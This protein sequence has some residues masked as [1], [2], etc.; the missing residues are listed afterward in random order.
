MEKNKKKFYQNTFLLIFFLFFISEEVTGKDFTEKTG[1]QIFL[2]NCNVCHKDGNNIIIPEKNLKL[3]TLK[4][5]GIENIEAIV[6]QVING[7]N[8]MPAFG[9]R[10]KEKDIEKVAHYILKNKFS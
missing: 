1:E 7:K 3:E 9:G 10:L 2:S 4:A 6:Y 5:N 8:G